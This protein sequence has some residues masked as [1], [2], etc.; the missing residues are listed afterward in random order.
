MRG[1]LGDGTKISASASV[2]ADGTWPLYVSLY[3]NQGSVI[4]SVT[5]TTLFRS[6]SANWFKPVSPLDHVYPDGFA[7]RPV[8][9]GA[10]YVSP[11]NGGPS[12]AESG[13]LTLSGG[14]LQ[15][16]LVKNV[17][18]AANGSVTV[19]PTGADKLTLKVN[20]TK[21]QISGGFLNP[22][23]GKTSKLAGTFLQ[24]NS[25]AA[26]FF[27]GTNQTGFAIVEPGP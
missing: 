5:Y 26:G 1:V 6:A 25:S 15:S 12:I 3:K 11:K 7:T 18:I 23:T 14:N 2:A 10:L 19:S 24:S 22:D 4:T 9:R 13:T 27:P 16:N 8:V 21:G 17:V 20:T